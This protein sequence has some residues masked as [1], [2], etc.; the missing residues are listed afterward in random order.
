[1][2][3]H[4]YQKGGICLIGIKRSKIPVLTETDNSAL[5]VALNESAFGN[6]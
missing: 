4:T 6:V 3:F 1:M 5:N 2:S